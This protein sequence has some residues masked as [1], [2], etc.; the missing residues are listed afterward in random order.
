VRASLGDEAKKPRYIETL[1]RRGYRFIAKIHPGPGEVKTTLPPADDTT[2]AG[3]HEAYALYERARKS[4]GQAGKATLQSARQDFRRAIEIFPDYALAHSGLGAAC[5]LCSLN[6]RDPAD[7]DAARLHLLRAIE[8]DS[9]IA[10]PYPWLCYVLMRK[11]RI[12]HALEAGLR[13]VE[14]QPD[15]VTTHYFLGLAYFAGAEADVAN[16]RHAAMHLRNAVRV[17]PQWQP[18]W[19]VLS[20]L[21]LLIGQYE[22]AEFFGRSL[23][24][25]TR[26]PRGTPFIGAEI[27]LGSVRL[28]RGDVSGA[29]D[30]LIGFLERMLESD[31]MYRDAMSGAAAC[32]L[33]DVELRH[34]PVSAALAAY[35]RAWHILQEYPQVNAYRRIA[36]RAQAGLAAAYGAAGERERGAKLLE[37]ASRLARDSESVENAAAAS[38][39]AEVYW[40]I[41][42]ASMRLGHPEKVLEAL[43]SAVRMGW[44]DA[45]WLESDPEFQSM[46]EINAFQRLIQNI[47]AWPGIPSIES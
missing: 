33:G 3:N 6:H 44:R 36:A 31:H 23:L 24:D 37:R 17:D 29:R 12:E 16:Y 35:R 21:F 10:E 8:L 39:M 19:Y 41:A 2:A 43:E 26:P 1:A 32:A 11:N 20:Y 9:E 34:G 5:A 4:F 15:L 22:E 25:T 14:L 45:S 18:A 27:T 30:L 7:L 46:R 38:S 40:T 42:T 13:G 47:R 28:R